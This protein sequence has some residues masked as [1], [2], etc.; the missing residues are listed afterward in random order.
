MVDFK[1]RMSTNFKIT[2]EQHSDGYVGLPSRAEGD[3]SWL[4]QQLVKF[5]VAAFRAIAF[6]LVREAEHIAMRRERR[7]LP[8]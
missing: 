3:G 4:W 2:V 5:P 6:K 1:Q 7:A 8:I